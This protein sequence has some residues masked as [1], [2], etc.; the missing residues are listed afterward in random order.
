MRNTLHVTRDRAWILSWALWISENALF[1]QSSSWDSSA[2]CFAPVLWTISSLL[3]VRK[4]RG[5]CSYC[6][7][8]LL[9]KAWD[10]RVNIV[11]I[12]FILENVWREV[13]L[14]GRT[15]DYQS[16]FDLSSLLTSLR[17]T[18]QMNNR[19]RR[20]NVGTKP[21]PH[22]YWYVSWSSELKLDVKANCQVS[23]PLYNCKDPVVVYV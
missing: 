18:P 12:L 13:V 2:R 17:T 6:L 20:S 22:L 11:K 16:C 8:P 21:N 23:R 1:S 19:L 14:C 4:L 9:P 10:S 7:S 3:H 5:F 15:M